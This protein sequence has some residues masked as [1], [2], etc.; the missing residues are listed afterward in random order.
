[1]MLYFELLRETLSVIG[2]ALVS[3]LIVYIVLSIL[4]W[5]QNKYN[6]KNIWFV[7]GSIALVPFLFFEL[8]FYLA[9]RKVDNKIV[10]PAKAYACSFVAK[11][12]NYTTTVPAAINNF[13]GNAV[14]EKSGYLK[15]KTEEELTSILNQ[16][17]DSLESILNHQILSIS[18]SVNSISTL[19][20]ENVENIIDTLSES[21]LELTIDKSSEVIDNAAE[22][23]VVSTDQTI[24]I[25]MQ[26]L[27]TN[28][29]GELKNKFPALSLFLTDQGIDGDS[30]EEI[31]S[32][33]FDK[34][35]VAI[36][37]FKRSRMVALIK[38]VL[39]FTVVSLLLGFWK[40]KRK[41]HKMKSQ[42]L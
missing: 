1:M 34:A 8:S 5:K 15:K 11:I 29:V 32:S 39:I 30:G 40:E 36:K 33:L 19:V 12:D 16:T 20:C 6:L 7:L 27:P 23:I 10:E 37:H 24:D 9:A 42:N 3:A 17:H 25:S 4:L 28:L 26:M 13:V 35:N 41:A 38:F 22:F 2:G 14:S 21:A 31:V 18:D